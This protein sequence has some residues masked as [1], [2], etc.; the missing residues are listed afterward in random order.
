MAAFFHTSQ[1]EPIPFE[2]AILILR[3]KLFPFMHNPHPW[4]ECKLPNSTVMKKKI[5]QQ[6]VVISYFL[7]SK[8]E[9]DFT[10]G[11]LLFLLTH[12]ANP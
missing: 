11:L 1:T 5:A 9:I 4:V 2:D 6:D 12:G 3:R 8:D 7:I 10:V